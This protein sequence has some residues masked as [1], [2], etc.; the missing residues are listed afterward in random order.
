MIDIRAQRIC[1]MWTAGEYSQYEIADHLRI[2]QGTV[3]QTLKRAGL[4][5]HPNAV[6]GSRRRRSR[7]GRPQVWPDCPEHL[8]DDY[9]LLRSKQIP[10]AEARSMLEG[11]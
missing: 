1:E 5:Q 3:N 10:A 7:G 6:E 4:R 9:R 11:R 8:K 2:S